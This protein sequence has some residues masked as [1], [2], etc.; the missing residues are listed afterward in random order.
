MKN[1]FLG[2]LFIILAGCYTQVLPP[3]DYTDLPISVT[4]VNIYTTSSYSCWDPWWEPPTIRFGSMWPNYYS[5]YPYQWGGGLWY[6]YA[7]SDS[8]YGE[9]IYEEMKQGR[10]FGRERNVIPAAPSIGGA[11]T[12]GSGFQAVLPIDLDHG[13]ITSTENS[14]KDKPAPKKV[15]NLTPVKKNPKKESKRGVNEIIKVISKIAL[16]SNDSGDEN[17]KEKSSEQ[18]KEKTTTESKSKKQR[19]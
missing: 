5:R 7:P 15:E 18:K 13:R 6:P 16:S 1:I 14:D 12:S 19:R 10:E 4:N 3:Q 11:N 17:T 2:M 8:Y 9:P